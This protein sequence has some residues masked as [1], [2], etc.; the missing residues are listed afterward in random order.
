[1]GRNTARSQLY[2]IRAETSLFPQKLLH[3]M[4]ALD[5]VDEAGDVQN[6]KIPFRVSLWN[7][8]Y[9]LINLRRFTVKLE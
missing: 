2:C 7:I 3:W 8:S 9:T 4:N 1:M 6:P 5:S